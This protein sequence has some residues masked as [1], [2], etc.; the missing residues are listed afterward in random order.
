MRSNRNRARARSVAP[1][2]DFATA[3][4]S[5]RSRS[6]L[7]CSRVRRLLGLSLKKVMAVSPG[8]RADHVL[9]GQCTLP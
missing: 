3:S 4:S 1:R 8:F 6:L 7:F 5:R 9:T 2:N